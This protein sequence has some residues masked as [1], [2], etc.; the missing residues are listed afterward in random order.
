ML[1]PVLAGGHVT[2]FSEETDAEAF[3]TNLTSELSQHSISCTSAGEEL[4]GESSFRISKDDP[5]SLAENQKEQK[6]A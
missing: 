3:H 5:P 2:R 4:E 1:D 6:L